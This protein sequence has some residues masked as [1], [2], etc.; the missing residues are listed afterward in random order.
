VGGFG[1]Q[2]FT[3]TRSR[4][5]A[6]SGPR[7]CLEDL[8]PGLSLVGLEPT[9]VATVVAVVPI[10]DGTVQVV[11][12]TPDGSLK[13]RLLGGRDEAAI[14]V[15]TAERP[16]AFDGDG[17]AFQLTCEAKRS[18]FAFTTTMTLAALVCTMHSRT[19]W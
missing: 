15:A 19:P 11:Y 14:A 8:E 5:R 7:I 12:K 4:Q 17:A 18:D 1:V 10:A 2:F 6:R 3:P 9:D 16:W 13:D